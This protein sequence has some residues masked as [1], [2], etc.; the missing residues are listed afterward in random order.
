MGR[1]CAKG[2]CWANTGLRG[3]ARGHDHPKRWFPKAGTGTG[4]GTCELA[5]MPI[6]RPCPR[7][8]EALGVGPAVCVLTQLPALSRSRLQRG[9]CRPRKPRRPARG[10]GPRTGWEGLAEGGGMFCLRGLV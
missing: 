8:P 9:T 4:S 1:G 6:F 10:P 2:W 5:K 7:P 3:A